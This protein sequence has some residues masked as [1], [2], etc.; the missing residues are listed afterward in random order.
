MINQHLTEEQVR[1]LLKTYSVLNV[2]QAAVE[3]GITLRDQF[4]LQDATGI[5]VCNPIGIS[6]LTLVNIDPCEYNINYVH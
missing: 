1:V 3:V 5:A 6:E 4:N 2:V